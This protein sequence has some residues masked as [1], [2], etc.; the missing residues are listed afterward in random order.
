MAY[1]ALGA[2]PKAGLLLPYNVVLQ[3]REGADGVVVTLQNPTAFAAKFGNHELESI[4]RKTDGLIQ[5]VV[6]AFGGTL[7]GKHPADLEDV[8]PMHPNAYP[9]RH[10]KEKLDNRR[11]DGSE[12]P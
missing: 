8:I 4:S 10:L 3:E 11:G 6:L 1:E 7:S 12:V 5:K 9:A 2:E